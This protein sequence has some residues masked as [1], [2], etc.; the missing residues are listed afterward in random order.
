MNVFF[1]LSFFAP[2]ATY[3]CLF[4]SN[5]IAQFSKLKIM[6]EEYRLDMENTLGEIFPVVRNVLLE[7]E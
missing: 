2:R 5:T 1:F 3:I 7:D 4:I 6:G